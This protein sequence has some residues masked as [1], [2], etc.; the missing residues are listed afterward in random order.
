[1]D[2]PIPGW[3]FIFYVGVETP[4]INSSD[5][6][7]QYFGPLKQFPAKVNSVSCFHVVTFFLS[8]LLLLNTHFYT[9][10]PQRTVLTY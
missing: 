1:M 4:S 3:A 8:S 9:T 2:S 7:N 6:C 5:A 10:L